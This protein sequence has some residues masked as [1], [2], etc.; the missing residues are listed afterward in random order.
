MK[1]S[2]VIFLFGTILT[3]LILSY[4]IKKMQRPS[5][6]VARPT[7]SSVIES[8]ATPAAV[9][10]PPDFALPAVNAEQRTATIVNQV[11]NTQISFFG[12][13]QDQQ[14]TPIP[15]AEVKFG[16]IDEFWGSGSTYETLSDANGLFSITGI[17]GAGL[18]VG[19]SKEG[20]DGIKGLSYQSFGYGMPPDSTRKAAPSPNAPAI[21]VLRRKLPAEPLYQ[22]RR[23]IPIPKDGTPIEISLKTG[24]PVSLQQ[25]DLKIECWTSDD[26]KDSQGRYE[27]HARVSVP[28]GG[29]MVR[30]DAEREF[31]APESGY[32]PDFEIHMPSIA[33]RWERSYDGQYWLILRSGTYAR[34]RLRLTTAGDHFATIESFLNPSGSRNLEYDERNV[35]K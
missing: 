23:D 20:Y 26:K 30:S 10:A 34:I 2:W 8:T 21:F 17:K 5:A 35:I 22:I 18:T 9:V 12:K 3:F 6:D 27:W 25:G 29:L 7:S 1:R 19:V 11:F 4:G 31:E 15:K 32:Q 28:G 24:K 14:G 33:A 16:A 13:V